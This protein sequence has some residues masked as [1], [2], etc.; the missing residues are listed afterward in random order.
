M[1]TVNECCHEILHR[2]E[3]KRKKEKKKSLLNTRI[4]QLKSCLEKLGNKHSRMLC[5]SYGVSTHHIYVHS[6]EDA[7]TPLAK[8]NCAQH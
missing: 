8:A 2:Q 7:S 3:K 5:N 1:V 6:R 4:P